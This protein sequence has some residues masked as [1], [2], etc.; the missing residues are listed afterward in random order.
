MTLGAARGGCR[1]VGLY[2]TV[3]WY[4]P[5]AVTAENRSGPVG[6]IVYEWPALLKA[7]VLQPTCRR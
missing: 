7:L 1:S 6:G 2:L 3:Q 5:G 4:L